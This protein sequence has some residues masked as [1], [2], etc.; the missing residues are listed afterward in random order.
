MGAQGIG[1]IRRG[2][3]GHDAGGKDAHAVAARLHHLAAEQI[4]ALDAVR[5]F[6][7]RVEAVVAVELLDIVFARVAVTPVHLDRQAV[8]LQ[9]PLRWPGFGDR[10]QEFQQATGALAHFGS[11]AGMFV[12]HQPRAVQAQTQ[13]PFHI[14]LLRQQHAP[15]VGVGD[16]R[17]LRRGRILGGGMASLRAFE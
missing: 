2:H 12:V 1:R 11:V 17:Q 3:I 7:D 8:R 14:R 9:T 10:G 13:R 5:A 4:H 6:M 15:H 16:D